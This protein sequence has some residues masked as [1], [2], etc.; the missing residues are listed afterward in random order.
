M[1]VTTSAMPMDS[2]TNGRS[3]GTNRTALD[4]APIGASRFNIVASNRDAR[5]IVKA[6]QRAT[7]RAISTDTSSIRA[8]SCLVVNR[9]GRRRIRT[10]TGTGAAGWGGP[11]YTGGAYAYG[12]GP[13][14]QERPL[15]AEY[16]DESSVSYERGHPV[17]YGRDVTRAIPIPTGR[18]AT[19]APTSV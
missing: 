10:T 16:S 11:G 8:S 7:S 19:N 4:S 5:A 13:R 14:D 1:E 9:S 15:D 2:G 18:K 12:N 17:R 6:P 3:G